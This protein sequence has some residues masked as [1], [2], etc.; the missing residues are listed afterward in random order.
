MNLLLICTTVGYHVVFKLLFKIVINRADSFPWKILPN[1]VGQFVNF[2]G[3]PRQSRPNTEVHDGL[4]FVNKLS[5]ILFKNK[6][7]KNFTF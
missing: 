3:L 1:F 6:V 2:R 4:P 7:F 5:P